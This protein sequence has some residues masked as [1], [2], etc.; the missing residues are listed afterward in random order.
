MIRIRFPGDRRTEL[1]SCRPKASWGRFAGH[2]ERAHAACSCLIRTEEIADPPIGVADSAIGFKSERNKPEIAFFNWTDNL[3]AGINAVDDGRKKLAEMLNS[4]YEAT[5]SG[6]GKEAPDEVQDRL[7]GYDGWPAFRAA[8]AAHPS[9]DGRK[10]PIEPHSRPIYYACSIISVPGSG[11]A[12]SA[13]SAS[14]S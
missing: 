2:Y 3:G 12:L 1:H 4:L 5:K 13:T 7:V 11:S 14:S 9:R 8:N 10:K 6:Q